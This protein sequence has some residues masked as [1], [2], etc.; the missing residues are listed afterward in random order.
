M[1]NCLSTIMSFSNKTY[2]RI[3]SISLLSAY[4]LVSALSLI[5]YHKIDL[6]RP[7]TISSSSENNLSGFGTFEGQNFICTIHQNYL[8]LHNTNRIDIAVCSPVLQYFNNITV[9]KNESYHSTLQF[10]N[11]NLRAPP[12]SS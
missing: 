9:V 1:K 5:H 6:N 4:I 3:I 10:N 8:L 11:I 7:N 12:I 2:R